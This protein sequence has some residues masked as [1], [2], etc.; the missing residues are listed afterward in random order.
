MPRRRDA[1]GRLLSA[2]AALQG[3]KLQVGGVPLY[4]RG[5]DGGARQFRS[6]H[7]V[8]RHMVDTCQCRMA[9]D[10]NE[11]EYEEFY[12]YGD[13]DEVR[14]MRRAVES[15]QRMLAHAASGWLGLLAWGCW[16]VGGHRCV[17]MPSLRTGGLRS[18]GSSRVPHWPDDKEEPL[19]RTCAR[20]HAGGVRGRCGGAGGRGRGWA[21]WR[22]GGLR[23]GGG[24]RARGRRQGATRSGVRGVRRAL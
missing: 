1:P 6:L 9:Y 8:Q 12:D 4:V 3:A 10:G 7:G 19:V 17:S 20:R 22:R 13:E 15:D 5:D 23:A 2:P 14:H 24:R 18:A 11:E 21:G 16:L